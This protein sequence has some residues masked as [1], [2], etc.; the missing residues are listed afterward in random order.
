MEDSGVNKFARLFHG[1]GDVEGVDVL[2]WIHKNQLQKEKKVTYPRYTATIRPEKDK[3]FRAR[4]TAGGDH[5]DYFGDISTETASMETIMCHWQSV[6]STT[7]A[8]YCTGDISS[9]YLES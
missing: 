7:N 9:M 6:L 8:K 3:P 4:I 5:F 2:E 1:Y